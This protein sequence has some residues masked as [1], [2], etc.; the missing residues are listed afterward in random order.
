MSTHPN[1][2]LMVALTPDDLSRK[3]MK[4]ILAEHDVIDTDDEIKINGMEYNYEIMEQDYLDFWQI[5]SKEGD[6]IFFDMVTYGYGESIKW[7]DLEAQKADLE[8]WAKGICERHNC[9]YEIRVC[10]NYW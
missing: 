2:I 7:S 3:T 1:T 6:L 10:S 4:A 9:S 8:E 5:S